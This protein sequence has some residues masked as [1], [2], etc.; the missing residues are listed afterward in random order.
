MDKRTQI[1]GEKGFFIIIGLISV[2]LFAVSLKMFLEAPKLSGKGTMPALCCLVMIITTLLSLMEIRGYPRAFE[3]GV[4]VLH[5]VKDTL[6]YI[7][8][9]KVGI[10]ALYCIIYAVILNVLGFAISTLIFLV[11]SM[12][13]LNS[14]KKFRTIIVCLVTTVCIILVFQYL[15]QVQLPKG[16]FLNGIF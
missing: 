9:G 8:P 6:F 15:F 10:I 7:F 4:P 16:G 11:A 14:Q 5:A 12:V 3:K 13:T 2:F 1:K